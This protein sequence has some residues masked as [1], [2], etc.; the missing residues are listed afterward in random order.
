MIDSSQVGGHRSGPEVRARQGDRQFDQPQ[1]RRRR[2]PAPGPARPPLRRGRRRDGVRRAGPG[3][4]GR[5]QGPHLPA[6]VQAADR[7]GRLSAGRHHLRSRTSSPSPPA[8]RSTTT[9]RSTSS[10]PRGRS[11]QACPGAKISGGVSNISLLVPRQRRGPRGDARGVSVPRDP[12]RHGHGHRQR[13]P[14]RGVRGDSQGAAGA[15]RRRA[16]QP[17]AR[18]HRAAGRVR[19]DGQEARA[20]G[21]EPTELAWRERAGRGAAEARAGQGHRRV[22]RDDVEEARQKYPTAA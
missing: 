6:G 16:A 20:G 10:R 11:K 12:R 14:A 9:T 2:V 18:R 3:R 17:P 13:R 7:G 1:G 4:R 15:R 5:R 22:H 19:R 8:S 21:R